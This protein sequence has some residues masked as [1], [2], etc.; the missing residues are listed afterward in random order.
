MTA[1]PVHLQPLIKEFPDT[2]FVL[3]HASY[4]FTREAGYLASVYKNVYLDFGLVFPLVSG[5]GQRAIIR[6]VLELCPTNKILF[7]SQLIPQLYYHRFP[8][9]I[10]TPLIGI[11]TVLS[12]RTLVA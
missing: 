12:R 1:S 5:D 2:K 9:T 4:P 10:Y 6:Q 11:H 3:L 7:S 8:L